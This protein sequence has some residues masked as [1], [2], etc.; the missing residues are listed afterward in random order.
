MRIL[1]CSNWF[2][3]SI[4]G[5]ETVSKILAEEWARAGHV[6]SVVTSTPSSDSETPYRIIRNPSIRE[7]YKLGLEADVIYQNLMSLRT[8]L[9]LMLCR[10]PVVITHASWLRRVDGSIGIENYLK[11]IILRTAT[12]VS[13]SQAIAAELPVTSITINNPFEAREFLASKDQPRDRDIVFLGRLV[14]DKGCD[15]LLNAVGLLKKQ[16]RHPSVTIIGDGPEMSPLKALALRLDIADQ[17]DFLGSIREGRGKI[18]ARH[19]CLA[20]PSLWAE[21]FG[22]VACEGIASGC[23][24]VASE[25]GGLMEAVGSCGLPFPNGDYTALSI[26]LS[27][28]LYEP[29]LR[30]ALIA[31]GPKH[32]E[33]FQDS[34][35]A[36]N[37]IDL[38]Q[39][40]IDQ[41]HQR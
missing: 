17:I 6:V 29:G 37:Y 19:R 8:L 41:Q 33:S 31:N 28:V 40:L 3:P 39:G 2:S 22:I 5:V 34:N 32:L 23:A 25:N 30:E 13:I 11:R 38:F 20:I 4:G 7:L 36:K 15:L 10:K 9:P 18:M 26:A 12:N 14:S 1:L 27:K 16:G 35:V 21:P 24:V